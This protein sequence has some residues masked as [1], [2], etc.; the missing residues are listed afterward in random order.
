MS[1]DVQLERLYERIKLV[2]GPGRPSRGLLCIMSFV[3]YLLGETHGDRP[4]TASMVIRSF[5]IQL[6]DCVPDEWRQE[7]KPFAPRIIGTNDGQE[8]ARGRLIYAAVMDE[9]LPKASAEFGRD[10]EG[11][12]T[13]TDTL[14]FVTP[15][16]RGV[17]LNPCTA[18]T[19][20]TRG[21]SDA[22]VRQDYP[23]LGV[24]AGNLLGILACHAPRADS[25]RWYWMKAIDL[26]DR[27]C[28]VGAEGRVPA[29]ALD[30]VERMQRHLDRQLLARQRLHQLVDRANKAT[31]A[32]PEVCRK[33]L[34]HVL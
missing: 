5:A 9:V 15:Y 27:L 18:V 32:V 24:F 6:N 21:I 13:D 20:L 10:F 34:E 25:R 16:H 11:H 33:A 2:A 3:T 26:L 29:I 23:L 12:I 8:R 17:V 4:L 7:L 31:R 1:A 28:D 14:P 22:Y 30:R 19:R